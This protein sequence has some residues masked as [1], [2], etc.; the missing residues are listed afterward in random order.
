MRLGTK[1]P[2]TTEEAQFNQAWP[3]AAMLVDG[4][5]GPDQ[6]L[7][8]RLSD[9]RIREIA[10]KVEVFETE[11]MEELCRLFEQGDPQ[12]R[13]ASEV[14]ITLK[15]GQSFNSGIVDGGLRFPPSEWDEARMADKF[16]WLA[17]Y[18][19]DASTLDETM[20][21]LSHFEKLSNVRQLTEKLIVKLQKQ[22]GAEKQTYE[23]VRSIFPTNPFKEEQ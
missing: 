16:H 1:L 2:N 3:I 20:D 17:D 22:G 4:E 13:F 6:T 10:Q 7:E 5:I 23:C 9:P 15:N 8:G 18:V 19:L 21:L 11:E 12:G 14:T